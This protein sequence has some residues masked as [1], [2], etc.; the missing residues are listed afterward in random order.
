[1]SP[2]DYEG[3]FKVEHD[4]A[5]PGTVSVDVSNNHL[6]PDD[7]DALADRLTE[8]ASTAR[9]E[10]ARVRHEGGTFHRVVRSGSKAKVEKVT[11]EP[12]V[13]QNEAHVTQVPR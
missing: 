12:R 2:I 8:A 7:A 13:L 4:E 3:I 6:N 5:K 11:L 10:Q 9:N 1:V